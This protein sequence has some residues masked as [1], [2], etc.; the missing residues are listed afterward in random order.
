MRAHSS[1]GIVLLACLLAACGRGTPSGV[2]DDDQL[3]CTAIAVAGLSIR[4]F[5]ADTG[6]PAASGAFVEIREGGWI[7]EG[8]VV[9]DD[10]IL[11]AFERPGIY[12]IVIR[13]AG[14]GDLRFEGV[15]VV[16]EDRC[17]VKG[18]VLEARLIPLKE[19]A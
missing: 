9:L 11:G 13:K 18:T 3:V 7:D 4:V 12:D 14:Y 15:P 6:L 10:V 2:E 1:I 19:G 16:S 5:D 8:A 17:H